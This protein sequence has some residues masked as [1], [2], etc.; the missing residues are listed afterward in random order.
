MLESAVVDV[1]ENAERYLGVF[2]LSSW[3]LVVNTYLHV[4]TPL[5]A[6]RG[7]S[8]TGRDVDLMQA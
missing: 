1:N 4:D 6:V 8:A 7:R 5:V 3:S 2:L